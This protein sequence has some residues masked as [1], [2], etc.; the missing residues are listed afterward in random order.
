MPS[1][2]S[3][4]EK[5]CAK[6]G[7]KMTS[8]RRVIVQV[9]ADSDDHPAAEDV[10]RRASRIEGRISLATVYRTIRLLEEAGILEKHD[11][12]DG[13]ARYEEIQRTHHDHLIDVDTGEVIEFVNEEI[14]ALQETVARELGYR[15]T[16]HRHELYGTRIHKPEQD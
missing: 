13:R 11:F 5:L 14:E 4:L 8:Q 9:L 15:L 7:L 6:K 10:Y 1:T 16:G 3:D 2:A 12:G